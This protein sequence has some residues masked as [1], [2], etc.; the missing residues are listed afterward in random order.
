MQ[1]TGPKDATTEQTLAREEQSGLIKTQSKEGQY[2]AGVKAQAFKSQQQSKVSSL[3]ETAFA[4]TA[5][6]FANH[7]MDRSTK[8]FD[9]KMPAITS[10]LSSSLTADAQKLDYTSSSDSKTSVVQSVD[11]QKPQGNQQILRPSQQVHNAL[12]A[13][14]SQSMTECLSGTR[15][16]TT[17]SVFASDTTASSGTQDKESTVKSGILVGP[18]KQDEIKD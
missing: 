3:G 10:S 18:L 9:S 6:K 1:T 5:D 16:A 4:G 13:S 2:S 14:K 11:L 7:Q 12:Q 8:S 15:L 17:A